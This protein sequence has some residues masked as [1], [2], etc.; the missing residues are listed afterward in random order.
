MTKEYSE[1]V[2]LL[3]HFGIDGLLINHNHHYHV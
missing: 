2:D 3:H 1:C